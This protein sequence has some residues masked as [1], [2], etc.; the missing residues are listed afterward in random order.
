[1]GRESDGARYNTPAAAA[2]ARTTI[3]ANHGQCPRAFP[4]IWSVVMIVIK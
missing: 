3:P 2:A 1:M 4:I